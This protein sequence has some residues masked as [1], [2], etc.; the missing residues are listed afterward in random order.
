MCTT[1]NCP[2]S[3]FIRKSY[4]KGFLQDIKDKTKIHHGVNIYKEPRINNHS[5]PRQAKLRQKSE[6]RFVYLA[7]SYNSFMVKR[8]CLT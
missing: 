4:S 1:V 3:N 2:P 5:G 6:P 7:S 8:I